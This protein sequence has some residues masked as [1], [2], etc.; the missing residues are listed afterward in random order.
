MGKRHGESL[1]AEIVDEV[2][3]RGEVI[4]LEGDVDGVPALHNEALIVE[5]RRS[6]MSHGIPDHA[7][8][9]ALP[10]ELGNAVKLTEIPR[11][12]MPRGCR[13]AGGV[14]GVGPRGAV[15]KAQDA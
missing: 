11:G 10:V 15:G 9:G 14:R 3:K 7:E 2:H 13:G 1:Q 12:E 6:G 8:D 5:L 4:G